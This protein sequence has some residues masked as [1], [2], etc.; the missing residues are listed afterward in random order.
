[1]ATCPT[2]E[3]CFSN[4][5]CVVFLWS[6]CFL[7]FW[8]TG[9]VYCTTFF[10]TMYIVQLCH[11]TFFLK[12]YFNETKKNIL[13]ISHMNTKKINQILSCKFIS[14]VHQRF[15]DLFAKTTYMYTYKFDR[16]DVVSTIHLLG[17]LLILPR[18]MSSPME[19]WIKWRIQWRHFVNSLV[20]HNL[21]HTDTHML[22]NLRFSPNVIHMSNVYYKYRMISLINF[23]F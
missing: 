10:W 8:A 16:F 5:R 2:F 1:M 6:F 22:G 20:K 11:T 14:F 17:L 19:L 15:I 12:T 13:L 9:D 23:H 7:L 21:I 18:S 3:N 4:L